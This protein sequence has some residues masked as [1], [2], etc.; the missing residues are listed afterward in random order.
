MARSFTKEMQAGNGG[1]GTGPMPFD[2]FMDLAEMAVGAVG[3]EF[4]PSPV[5]TSRIVES[6]FDGKVVSK[7]RIFVFDDDDLDS[8]EGFVGCCE[9]ESGATPS[10]SNLLGMHLTV[11]LCYSQTVE[12]MSSAN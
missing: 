5:D 7:T 9:E 1:F 6:K 12:V 2:A 8:S 4:S 3:L 11:S 10:V